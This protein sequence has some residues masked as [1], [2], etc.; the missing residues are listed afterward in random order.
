VIV[1][2]DTV[3]RW[4]REIVRRRWAAGSRHKRPGRP[5]THRNIRS[6]VLRLARENP[7]WGYRRIRGELAGLGICV[8]LSTVWETLKKARDRPGTSPDRAGLEPVPALPGASHP[9]R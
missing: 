4:H 9:G 8:A 7:G 6:L 1:T 5:A 2:P 3:L